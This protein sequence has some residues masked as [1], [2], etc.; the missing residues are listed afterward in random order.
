L[1]YQLSYVI[2][3]AVRLNESK[4][5]E[6][7]QRLIYPVQLVLFLVAQDILATRRSLSKVV[8]STGF[9]PVACSLGNCCSIR[10]SYEDLAFISF[11]KMRYYNPLVAF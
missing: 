2:L 11:P 9:E 3:V 6:F 7:G 1:L 8:S 5:P 10:L 4:D